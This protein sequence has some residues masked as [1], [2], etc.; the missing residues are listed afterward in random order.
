[1][2]KKCSKNCESIC[3]FCTNYDVKNKCCNINNTTKEK[4]EDCN[5]D[6]FKCFTLQPYYNEKKYI[7]YKYINSVF[8]G[9]ED[10]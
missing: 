1:M 7:T 2:I 4:Y 10:I 9:V 8:E 5:C 6:M 3:G